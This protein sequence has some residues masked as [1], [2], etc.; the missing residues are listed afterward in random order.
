M[1]KTL[2]LFEAFTQYSDTGF[3]GDVAVDEFNGETDIQTWLTRNGQI[4]EDEHVVGISVTLFDAG[5]WGITVYIH[6]SQ[7]EM[8]LPDIVQNGI[9][10]QLRQLD[11]D[12]D[13]LKFLNK[14]GRF[15][16][17]LR[18]KCLPLSPEHKRT[19]ID[20]WRPR[21]DQL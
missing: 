20:T 15:E 18:E 8:S 3:R 13:P 16:I 14:L 6:R 1:K 5:S 21:D 10:L 7:D 2:H 4:D 9:S 12:M 17:V 19:S 11:I